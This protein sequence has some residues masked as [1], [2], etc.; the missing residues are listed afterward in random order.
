MQLIMINKQKILNIISAKGKV[1]S[2]ELVKSVGVSRQYVNLVISELIANK[3]VIK[4]G[5]TRS[6]FYVSKNYI[7]KHPDILPS[8]IKKT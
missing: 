4:I 1:T 6:A 2:S 5:G 8:V 7:A 3:E